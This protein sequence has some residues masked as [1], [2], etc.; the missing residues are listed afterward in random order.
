MLDKMK[1]NFISTVS[2]EL[3]TPLTTIKAFVELLLLKQ[4]MP[5][6]RK[7]KLMNT[8]NVE[9][10]RLARLI[11]DLLDLSRIEAGSMKWQFSLVSMEEIIQSVI[12]SMGVL[13][14][15]KG[16]R[17]AVELTPHLPPVLGDRDRLVQVVTNILSNA[18]KFTPRGG[19]IRVAL[20]QETAQL[21]VE[22]SDCGIGIPAEHIDLI[23]EKFHRSDDML[24]AATEGTG[25]GLAITRQ[26]V[27]YHGGS[28]KAASTRGKGSTFTVT[29]PLAG[30][31]EI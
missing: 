1:T 29:L 28:I 17:V 26:I 31:G 15:N 25:L 16:L 13:F 27:E 19:S 22:I 5:D 2:H 30:T 24:T 21:V 18:V 10:D 4:G 20:R 9:T 6:E 23:F 11:S 7:V 12:E 3:R 8:V 14:E